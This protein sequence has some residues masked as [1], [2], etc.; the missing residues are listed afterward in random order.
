[1][2]P[3]CTVSRFVRNTSRSLTRKFKIEQLE[4]DSRFAATYGK[5]VIPANTR[6]NRRFPAIE[7]MPVV[8]LNFKKLNVLRRAD[9][10]AHSA[11]VKRSCQMKL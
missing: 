4:I 8:A 1:M 7:N 10:R 6:I 11:H 3:Q 5:C 9:S 2:H